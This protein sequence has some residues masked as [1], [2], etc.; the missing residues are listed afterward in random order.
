MRVSSSLGTA[1]AN[2]RSAVV[3]SGLPALIDGTAVAPEEVVVSAVDPGVIRGDGVFE[4]VRL[5][6]G[7]ALAT[8]EHL[9]RLARSARALELEYDGSALESETER[10]CSVLE[11]FDGYI[12][13][14]VTRLGTRLL[15]AEPPIE[16]PSRFRLL[17]VEHAVSPLTAGVKALSYAANCR[18][19]RIAE[20]SG[21]DDA[22]LYDSRRLVLE[23]PFASFG[24]V[25]EGTLAVP[26]LEGG[27]L[28][29]VTRRLLAASFDHLEVRE[30]SIDELQSADEACVLGTGMEVAPVSE[31][32]GLR[33]FSED[34]PVVA[35][36]AAT[37]TAAIRRRLGQETR[38]RGG[39]G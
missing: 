22:L 16:F 32:E 39:E 29:S 34:G 7:V 33:A 37:L 21:C 8:R 10:L 9:E 26:P 28:D 14:V 20:D 31:I 27:I 12:R 3:A 19:K 17:P 18:A 5:Y 35:A 13:I 30:L 4:V 1:T 36:A 38:F 15:I 6:D 25:F 24:A 2:P 11:G 23:L